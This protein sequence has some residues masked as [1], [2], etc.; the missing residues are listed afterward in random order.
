MGLNIAVLGRTFLDK[1]IASAEAIQVTVNPAFLNNGL[2]ENTGADLIIH[3]CIEPVLQVPD[4][5]LTKA[6]IKQ[7]KN[8]LT[9]AT[10]ALM[11]PILALSITIMPKPKPY[12]RNPKSKSNR[13][14]VPGQK[15]KVKR[16]GCPKR[17]GCNDCHHNSQQIKSFSRYA[18]RPDLQ[19]RIHQN[20]AGHA[21]YHQPAGFG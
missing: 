16:A 17:T 7:A 2:M 20:R 6:D 14:Q 18:I 4:E 13:N 12:P 9:K 1:P 19:K 3:E 21:A 8:D 15:T 5:A 11:V 10:M